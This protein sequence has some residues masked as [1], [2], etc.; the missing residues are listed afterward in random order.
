METQSKKLDWAAVE[1]IAAD[2]IRQAAKFVQEN[3]SSQ[4]KDNWDRYYGRQ[5][6]N[7]RKGRSKYVSRDLLETIEWILPTLI[8]TFT[9]GDAKVEVTIEGQEPMI[10]KALMRHI[11]DTLSQDDDNSLFVLFYTWFKDA[12]VSDTGFVKP[13]WCRET[14][15]KTRTLNRVPADALQQLN[16]REDI[17]INSATEVREGAEVYYDSVRLEQKKT[18]RNELD[19]KGV[20][21]WEFVCHEKCRHINDEYGK[22][23]VTEVT[24]DYLQRVDKQ[25]RESDGKPFFKGLDKL[26][27]KLGSPSRI[28]SEESSYRN[29]S[30]IAR[31]TADPTQ[32]AKTNV[33]LCEWYTRLDVSGNGEMAD[34]IVWIADKD[35]MLRYEKNEDGFIPMSGLSPILDCY[36]MFGISLSDLLV[37]LQ[38]LKTMLTRR[39]LENFANLNLGRTVVSDKANFDKY[40]W[41]KGVPG[42]VVTGDPEGVKVF[43]PV[44]VDASA[45]QL[46]EYIEGVKE[47]RAGIT[48][49]NQGSDAD[50]LN[51]TATGI[52]LIQSATQQRTDLIAR[53]MGETGIKDFYRKCVMLYQKY[54]T[55]EFTV[56]ITGRDVTVTREQIQGK[57][58]VRLNLGIEAQVG[59]IEAQ[60]IE[61]AF[62]FLTQINQFYPGL[63]GPQQI[64]NL[65]TKYVQSMGWKQSEDWI[66][67]IEDFQ[68]SLKAAKDEAAKMRQAETQMKMAE[69]KIKEEELKIKAR[70]ADM[71]MLE[72]RL[73][74]AETEDK[75]RQAE[76]D[77]K[78]RLQGDLARD[79]ATV[80]AKDADA[81]ARRSIK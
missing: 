63:Q 57:V 40:Q 36:K 3:K 75:N 35:I 72:L 26:K 29:T 46:L 56:N 21:H 32:L 20:P 5:L 48:R 74:A 16:A 17:T 66:N 76:R 41:M 70:E 77:S 78:R 60:K 79:L 50:S 7:E 65:V 14:E 15:K 61:R 80:A 10:G 9:S 45:F 59:M 28:S 8:R 81:S 58:R 27:D 11:H 54:M 1:R 12:L 73:E 67:T 30:G 33:E 51:K 43:Y 39:L 69:L 68:K 38:N 25:Y 6:G 71:K 31:N 53:V 49:Y 13:D 62:A 52:S 18:I 19:V 44:P 55:D 22:G 47:Q 24:F 64:H 42:D 23:H 34:Y 2:E 4:R 37:D